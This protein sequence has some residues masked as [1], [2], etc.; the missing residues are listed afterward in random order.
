MSG[1]DT[2]SREER[3]EREH[4]KRIVL[5]LKNYKADSLDRLD[6]SRANLR[7]VPL[8]QQKILN[9]LG[10]SDRIDSLESC[11]ELNY[12]IIKMMIEDLDKM[13]ENVDE[14]PELS[15]EINKEGKEAEHGCGDGKERVIWQRKRRTRSDDID[16]VHSTIKQIVRDWSA[17]GA[18]ER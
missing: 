8:R 14:D 11:V 10:Y 18:A 17:A 15:R 7:K 6:R 2:T 1:G 3:E 9:T 16:K 4:F 5:A 13:F 12:D